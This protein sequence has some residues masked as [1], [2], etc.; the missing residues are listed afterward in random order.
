ML[1][2]NFLRP[3]FGAKFQTEVPLFLKVPEFP[4]NTD[5]DRHRHG[6]GAISYTALAQ[7]GVVKI[8]EKQWNVFVLKGCI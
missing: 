8:G 3:E 2:R 4:Y 1:W 5:T 6:H 7:R